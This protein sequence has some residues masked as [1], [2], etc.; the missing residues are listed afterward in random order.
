[1][2][3]QRY[4]VAV[5]LVF[6]VLCGC[7]LVLPLGASYVLANGLRTYG[8]SHVILQLGY[9]G[10]TRMNIPVVSFQQDLGEERLLISLTDTE[11][12]YD[13]GHLFQ[14]R[15]HRILLRDVAIHVLTVHS[16]D[17]TTGG[18]HVEVN[19][20]EESSPWK[21]LTAGDLLRNI[22]ILPFSELQLEHVTVFREQ[23]TGPL[24]KVTID[25]ALTSAGNEIGG[26]LSFRG[27]DTGSYGLV[28]AGNSASTWSATLSSTRPHAAPIVSWQSRSRPTD[29][30]DIKVDGQLRMNVQEL[31][32]FIALLVPIGPELEKVTGQVALDWA[33][34]AA[35][36]AALGSLWED[37]HTRVDG[38]VRINL[39]LPALKGVAKD[40]A[41]AYA[42]RFVG[43]AA[44]AEWAMSPGVLLTATLNTQPR[45]IPD[46]VRLILPHGDQPVRIENKE[47]VQGTLYW[48]E[49]PIRTVAQ[50]PLQVTYGRASGPLV[51]MFET[52]RAEGRG[53]ELILAEGAYQLEGVLPRVLTERLSAKEAAGGVRG[54]VRLERARI[55]GVLLPPSSI[56]VKQI[57]QGAVFVPG[58]TLNLSEPLTVKCDLIP[59]HCIGGPLAATIRTPGVRIGGQTVT[60]TQGLLSIQD[61]ETRGT[62]WTTRGMLVVDGVNVS[63]GTAIPSPSHWVT[64]FS[65]DQTSIGADLQGDLP[66]HKGLVT[67]RI[68]QSLSTAYGA[69]HGTIGPV[70]FD[71]AER[72]LSRFIRAVGPSND[73]LD[74]TVSAMV[75][76]VWDNTGGSQ[77]SNGTTITSATARVIAENVSGYYHDYGIRGVST[78]M[79][80]RADG[81]ESILT[82]Q[83]ASL[84]VGAFQSGVEV[85]NIRAFYQARW[86]LTDPL[87]RVE[88]KDF[89]CEAFGGTITSPGLVVDLPSSSSTTVFSLRNLDLAKI[90][91]VEQQRG[92]QGTGTLN[93]T[94]PVTITPRGVVV[95]DGVIEAQP[96]GGVIRHLSTVESPPV[97]S[98]SDTPL[99]LVAQALNNFHYKFLRVGVR[100]G[101]TGMLDLSARLEGRNPDL[102]QTPPIH[103]NLTV[104][105]HIPTLLKSLRLIEEIPGT[106]ERKYKRLSSS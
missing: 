1:M 3:T 44:Q 61:M 36:R 52:T 55:A 98:E 50:G 73:L 78:S 101:E 63:A 25:G 97:L 81:T 83:P 76:V 59:R 9:P 37:E 75:D 85:T 45:L 17:P 26:H 51:A 82:T 86:K 106:I 71:G 13:L 19:N 80:L 5:L 84:V 91:S 21:L 31:A 93:G 102:A 96:P 42:G 79:V 89:Q 24:R 27:R 8:Y 68:E 100:Y 46:V 58:A 6:V 41:L 49:T 99:Q 28:V 94:L 87:P 66:N 60:V 38:Q 39:T 56:T 14:G 12:Q 7:Y 57:G 72:R 53:N 43:N 104:Q 77:S 16:T 18:T 103:F 95:D 64:K 22:P 105:E 65:A 4:Q 23:A 20:D 54:T 15:A 29:G 40:I 90:L 2:L 88:V 34:V 10:W 48:K 32:P 92:L 33:G 67:A 30:S 35:T 74:G 11:I 62:D 47:V 70:Q 69:L